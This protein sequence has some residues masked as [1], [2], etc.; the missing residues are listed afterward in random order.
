MPEIERKVTELPRGKVVKSVKMHR[1]NELVIEFEDGTR[2][3][4][5][6]ADSKLELSIT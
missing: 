6:I 5:D 2:L 4:V 3:F 1:S